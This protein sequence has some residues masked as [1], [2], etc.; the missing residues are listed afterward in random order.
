MNWIANH[1]INAS[2]M[3]LLKGSHWEFGLSFRSHGVCTG[4]TLGPGLLWTQSVL[5]HREKWGSGGR[6]EVTETLNCTGGKGTSASP[7]AQPTHCRAEGRS[8]SLPCWLRSVQCTPGSHW[9]LQPS[10]HTA[11]SR[12]PCGLPLVN[13]WSTAG[14]L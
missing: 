1:V 13:C 2:S 9:P 11:G 5:W 8:T 6:R 14:L 3:Q 4:A 10:G 7:P 12:S